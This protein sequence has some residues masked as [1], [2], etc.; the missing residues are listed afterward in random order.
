MGSALELGQ[1]RR[2]YSNHLTFSQVL[3]GRDT[4]VD[5]VGEKFDPTEAHD[6]S[7]RRRLDQDRT[8]DAIA[9]E[10]GTGDDPGSH[11]VDHRKH[12]FVAVIGIF[13][14]SV[15]RQ[16]SWRAAPALVQCR[17]ESIGRGDFAKLLFI[18]GEH[19]IQSV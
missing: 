8:Q 1:Q 15:R 14:H 7:V 18:H 9:V 16:S 10:A 4:R 19:T 6:F 3:Y 13:G 12:R 5:S 17:D 2:G 11:L